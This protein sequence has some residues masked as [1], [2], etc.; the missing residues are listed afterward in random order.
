[1]EPVHRLNTKKQAYRSGGW[2]ETRLCAWA[3]FIFSDAVRK[4]QVVKVKVHAIAGTRLSL[5]MREVDQ[6]TGRDLKPRNL[7]GGTSCEFC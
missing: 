2:Q 3:G 4:G 1:M 6:A 7:Q 5:T